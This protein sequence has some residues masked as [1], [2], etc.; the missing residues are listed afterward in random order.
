MRHYSCTRKHKIFFTDLVS[1]CLFQSPPLGEE[2][3]SK[4]SRRRKKKFYMFWLLNYAVHRVTENLVQNLQISFIH[5]WRPFE[6][7]NVAIQISGHFKIEFLTGI[8]FCRLVKEE[9][10]RLICN[11]YEHIPRFESEEIVA[12]IHIVLKCSYSTKGV[13]CDIVC[14][15]KDIR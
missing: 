6:S 10:W 14:G 8:L 7:I 12:S 2:A 1:S 4:H 15:S 3:N 9:Y 13:C 5:P 11:I